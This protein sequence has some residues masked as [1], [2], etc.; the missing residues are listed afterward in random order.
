MKRLALFVIVSSLICVGLFAAGSADKNKGS[1]GETAKYTIAYMTPA[2]HIPFWKDVSDGI[3]QEADKIGGIKIIDSDSALSASTQLKNVQDLI[4][5]GVSAIIISPTDSASCPSVLEL[6]E[7]AKIPVIICDI[8]TDS[9][10]Y[11]AFIISNNYGGANDAGKYLVAQMK[12]KGVQGGDVAV[13]TISLARQ[14][15][16]DRTEGFKAALTEVNSKVVGLLE[17]KEYTRAESLRFAQDLITANPKLV[18]LFTEH[19]EANLGAM[20]AIDTAAKRGQ[21]IHVGFDGSPEAVQAIKD[22]KL[23]AASMQQPVLMGREA[24]K[25]A[26]AILTNKPLEKKVVVPTILVTADNVK[27]VEK[28]LIDNVYPNELKASKK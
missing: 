2:L 3:R 6:A 15:G 10:N 16:R 8:G 20:P 14:N 18:G 5:S 25:A 27:D 4:T 28:Q 19:D 7:K 17:C 13:I 1:K 11:A 26:V 24:L 21:I 12:K 22:G 9:G 23:A